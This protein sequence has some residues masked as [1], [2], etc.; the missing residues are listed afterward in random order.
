MESRFF[1]F[2]NFGQ[3]LGT[4]F[5]YQPAKLGILEQNFESASVVF[6]FRFFRNVFAATV[7]SS[8][9]KLFSN[10]ISLYF[11][12]VWGLKVFLKYYST[13]WRQSVILNFRALILWLIAVSLDDKAQ[14]VI[15]DQKLQLIANLR[16]LQVQLKCKI[17]FFYYKTVKIDKCERYIWR[18]ARKLRLDKAVKKLTN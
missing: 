9:L 6:A 17:C 12:T 2:R 8:S 10:Q 14:Q 13:L 18:I 16:P 1:D 11:L 7:F 3:T 5:R 15:L 4:I